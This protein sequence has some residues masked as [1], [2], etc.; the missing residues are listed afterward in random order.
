MW[1]GMGRNSLN[2]QLE[3]QNYYPLNQIKPTVAEDCLH[4]T[5]NNVR[6]KRFFMINSVQESHLLSQVLVLTLK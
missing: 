1:K 3:L 2:R 5:E 4:L 6:H